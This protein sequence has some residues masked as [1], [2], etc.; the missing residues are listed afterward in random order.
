ML[1]SKAVLMHFSVGES[2]SHISCLA[3]NDCHGKMYNFHSKHQNVGYL[4]DFTC[5]M[6]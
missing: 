1:Y 6:S 2:D 3:F 4:S 5:L